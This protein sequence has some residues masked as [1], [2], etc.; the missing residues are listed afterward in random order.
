MYPES[1]SLPYRMTS[2]AA[3][4][5]WVTDY[6]REHSSCRSLEDKEYGLGQRFTVV[7]Q[8]QPRMMQGFE[9]VTR[10][11]PDMVIWAL[12]AEREA[13]QPAPSLL[14]LQVPQQ[15][16]QQVPMKPGPGE[17]GL[18]VPVGPGEPGPR[19]DRGDP[20]PN[21]RG[22]VLHHPKDLIKAT[23]DGNPEDLAYFVVRVMKFVE[24]WAHL[25]SYDSTRVDIAAWL[26]GLA[27][28][29]GSGPKKLKKAE[30]PKVHMGTPVKKAS[31]QPK[32]ATALQ[33]T[34]EESEGDSSKDERFCARSSLTGDH[35]SFPNFGVSF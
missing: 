3:T 24:K 2:E 25:F 27:A 18:G 8:T 7:E 14:P 9:K 26:R 34:L 35:N 4:K 30:Q 12:R 6:M 21:P 5:A 28:A 33:V 31:G 22:L 11:I 32:F 16:P 17:P 10:A 13:Q 15:V 23:L 29:C 1:S 19:P 20:A